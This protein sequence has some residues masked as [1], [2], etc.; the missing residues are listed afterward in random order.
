MLKPETP[1]QD[2]LEMVTLEMLVPQDHLLRKLSKAIDFS[3]IRAKV[4]SLYC[5]NNGRPA[6]DP[7]VL[8]KI[9]FIGYLFGIRS[10]RRLVKEIEV[11]VAYRW[12]L[13]LKLTD[14][15]IHHS[16]LSANRQKRFKD[17]DIY[18][19][20]FDEI[21]VKAIGYE[22]VGGEYLYTDSTHLKANANKGKFIEKQTPVNSRD[23]LAEL[24]EAIKIERQEKGK[25]EFAPS[26]TSSAMRTNKVSTTDPDS[27]F[28][29]REGKPKGF[30]YLDHRTVDGKHGIITDTYATSAT[31]HDSI[32]Y[33]SR[34][35]RQSERFN[36]NP[37]GVGLDS[38]Y[39]TPAICKGLSDRNIYGVIGYRRPVHKAGYLYKREY[40]YDKAQDVYICPNGEILSYATTQRNGYRLYKSNPSVCS[41]C[42]MRNQC[43]QS[44][45]QQ[46]VITRH[47]WED[48]KDEVNTH[49][50]SKVGK[51]IYA[52]RKET[53]ERS[54]ADAKELHGHRYARMRGLSKVM[55]QCL[56]AA[57]CQ[58]MKK[59]AL[60][61]ASQLD[62][63]T[64][65][66]LFA[67]IVRVPDIMLKMV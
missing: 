51:K 56:L 66:L 61:L 14:K 13:G 65:R 8:F 9:L 33:L 15:V 36:L 44:K 28:M 60:W 27:G 3:F 21:V 45:N 39:Y 19:D 34:L 12:F 59:I 42:P 1:S 37:I 35:D 63:P 32:P 46:K 16:T 25:Q 23:Y 29:T 18:Q 67:W 50:L 17:S 7:V 48:Y 57:A 11:N 24:D 2:E 5:D 6:V 58:N 30:F 55:I 10:E 52:R 54:F 64:K 62:G 41:S 47:I 53:V 49:R 26:S 40:T 38:G 31:M 22:L 20:I 43:T 4:S